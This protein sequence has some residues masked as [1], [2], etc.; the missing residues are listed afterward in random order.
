MIHVKNSISNLDWRELKLSKLDKHNGTTNFDITLSSKLL[1]EYNAI[2]DFIDTLDDKFKAAGS[3][4]LWG[5]EDNQSDKFDLSIQIHH[6]FNNK[7]DMS[8]AGLAY[9]FRG[10]G[11]GKKIYKKMI[12]KV[13][14]ISSGESQSYKYSQLVW[15]GLINDNELYTL[16]NSKWIY[17]FLKSTPPAEIITLLKKV[18]E[19][20]TKG[21]CLF[22]EDFESK[23]LELLKNSKV[24]HHFI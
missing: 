3:D 8:G 17:A 21:E 1:K 18:F 12:S 5:G 11:L 22:D 23:H 4:M 14:F 2:L 10:L 6:N 20:K 9:A 19:D 24:A 15:T 13:V 7:I 16:M